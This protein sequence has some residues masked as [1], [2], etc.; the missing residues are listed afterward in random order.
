MEENMFKAL[1]RICILGKSKTG[2]ST[3]TWK[4]S[5]KKRLN[6]NYNLERFE[7]FGWQFGFCWRSILEKI[8]I[9]QFQ[10]LPVLNEKKS[11]ADM[12]FSFMLAV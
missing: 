1:A 8:S 7:S 6:R 5:R 4:I 2:L 12:G 10:V 3:I 9:R 11:T